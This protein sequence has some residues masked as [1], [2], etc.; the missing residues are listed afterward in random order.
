M[1]LAQYTS[2]L[3]VLSGLCNSGTVRTGCCF[4]DGYW[5]SPHSND[6]ACAEEHGMVLYVGP[7]EIA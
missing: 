2:V 3:E 6:H 4:E 1:G 5:L 7:Y